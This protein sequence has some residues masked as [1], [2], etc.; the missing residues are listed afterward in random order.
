MEEKNKNST[1]ESEESQNPFHIKYRPESFDR[2]LGNE[3]AVKSIK[4]LLGRRDRPHTYLLVGPS[5]CGKTTLA[6][7]IAKDLGCIDTEIYEINA[8]NNRGIDTIR[9]LIEH[10]LYEPLFGDVK[11]ILFD[12]AHG[13][14]LP[15]QEALLKH[16]EDTPRHVYIIFCTTSPEKLSV[17]LKNRCQTYFLTRLDNDTL[18]SLIDQ[19]LKEEKA[20]LSPKTYELL[21]KAA[22]GSPRNALILL[23]KIINL[24]EDEQERILLSGTEEVIPRDRIIELCRILIRESPGA[25]QKANWEDI[26][27]ILKKLNSSAEEIRKLIMEYMGEVILDAPGEDIRQRA[28]RIIGYFSNGLRDFNKPQ[29]IRACYQATH[30][31]GDEREGNSRFPGDRSPELSTPQIG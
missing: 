30:K 5:G 31:F 10:S 4:R 2:F 18:K 14:T 19:V 23:Q 27:E 25:S 1:P 24:S 7:I 21:L 26:R 16:A 3:S 12:E 13:L 22:D 11:V 17:T 20:E 28:M 8:S 29:L 9:Q 15:A 6:R